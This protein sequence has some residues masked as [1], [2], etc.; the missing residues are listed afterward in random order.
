[1]TKI[2]FLINSFVL[3]WM[4][5]VTF[6]FADNKGSLFGSIVDKDNSY[7]VGASV[8]IED[9]IT[10]KKYSIVTN[11][12]GSYEITLTPSIY[13]ME[14][15][16]E[17]FCLKMRSP[18]EI[19]PKEKLNIN[20][21]LVDCSIETVIVIGNDKKDSGTISQY[22]IPYKEDKLL[23]DSSNSFIGTAWIQYGKKT[24]LDSEINYEQMSAKDTMV[25]PVYLSYNAIQVSANS[26][27]LQP[28][29]TFIVKGNVLFEDG[30]NSYNFEELIFN[31]KNGKYVFISSKSK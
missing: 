25:I 1:M 21:N 31:L 17:G 13:K 24:L 9:L 28:S 19:K 11:D 3:V 30:K 22:Q 16:K 15:K 26:M 6:A 23:I 18:F 27:L 14:V 4:S 12:D 7:I 2:L 29:N 5:S 8:T 10:Q 20:L